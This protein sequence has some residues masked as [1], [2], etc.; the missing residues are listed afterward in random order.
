MRHPVLLKE[1][2]MDVVELEGLRRLARLLREELNRQRETMLDSVLSASRILA[3][4]RHLEFQLAQA[5]PAPPPAG[6]DTTDY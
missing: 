1:A 2:I 5:E 6:A 4:A 3:M